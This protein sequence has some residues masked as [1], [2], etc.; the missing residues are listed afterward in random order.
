MVPLQND[1]PVP[2]ADDSACLTVT[3]ENKAEQQLVGTADLVQAL[4]NKLIIS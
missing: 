2:D 3:A 1:A 4:P